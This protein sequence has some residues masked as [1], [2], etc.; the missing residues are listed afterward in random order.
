[1]TSIY[2][3]IS[4]K[5]T[6]ALSCAGLRVSLL[7]LHAFQ[8]HVISSY[9]HLSCFALESAHFLSRALKAEIYKS[10]HGDP[11]RPNMSNNLSSFNICCLKSACVMSKRESPLQCDKAAMSPRS[12]AP[13]PAKELV[14]FIMFI[15]H[16]K[17]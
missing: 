1:M 5:E 14:H 17:A 8:L 6:S 3:N 2:F 11:E 7:E 10:W 15:K 9:H 12:R 16:N 13:Q 4:M